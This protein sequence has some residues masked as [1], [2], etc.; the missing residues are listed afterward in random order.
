M[1]DIK[2]TASGANFPSLTPLL[3]GQSFVRGI[4]ITPSMMIWATWTPCGPN[5]LASDWPR[6][7]RANLPAAKLW[8]RA[9]PFNDAVA[10]VIRRDGGWDDPST[11]A[12]RDGRTCW[13][14]RKNPRLPGRDVSREKP[15]ESRSRSA[16][17]TVRRSASYQAPRAWPRGRASVRSLRS[18]C[19]SLQQRWSCR[20]P[21]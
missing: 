3:T 7:L 1:E 14:K 12:R 2:L 21:S 19:R 9:D 5:S 16:N 20:T 4:S 15:A 18:H 6:A 10:P 8:N 17:L 13:A 11:E